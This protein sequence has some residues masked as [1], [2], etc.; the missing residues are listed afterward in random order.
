MEFAFSEFGSLHLGDARLDARMREQME[1]MARSPSAS[2]QGACSGW[3]ETIGACRMFNNPKVTAEKIFRPHRENLLERASEHD[4]IALIQDTTELDY[5]TH[6]AM[7]ERGVLNSGHRRGFLLHSQYAVSG[8]RVPLGIWRTKLLA[9]ERIGGG[10]SP[11]L[12]IEEK[13]SFRWVE[14]VRHAQA[15]ARELPDKEVFSVGDREGDVYEVL[16]ECARARSEEDRG[17]HLLVRAN[18]DRTVASLTPC[19]DSE[20]D[21][22]AQGTLF[23]LTGRARSLGRVEFT[24]PSRRGVRTSRGKTAPFHRKPRTVC[25]RLKACE[26]TLPP[27]VRPRKGV[28]LGPCHMWMVVAEETGRPEDPEEEPL[29]W[30]L[31]TTYPVGCF[32]DARKI[33]NLYMRRWDI[34]VFHRVLKTGCKVEHLRFRD[35][36]AFEPAL[37]C[38]MIV[39]WRLQY[40]VHMGRECPD[41]PCSAVFAEQEWRAALAIDRKVAD[42]RTLEEPGLGE[43][44][45]VVARF[46]GHLGRKNDAPPGAQCMWTGLARVR[47]FAIAIDVCR[48]DS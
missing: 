1:K 34:E 32:E 14:G 10:Y 26:V 31:L 2:V 4:C 11:H 46:G 44:I 16:H 29:F 17:A 40:L 48:K 15:L 42:P 35:Y 23:E 47:D 25:L 24:I 18:L 21:A 7:R 9:R 45:R 3:A 6:T 41:L 20:P 13:E 30:V 36:G 39:A 22:G 28:K 8:T 38:N 33:L 19:G 5:S 37:A 12:P 43:M 27:P